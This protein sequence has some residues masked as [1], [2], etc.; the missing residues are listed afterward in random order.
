MGGGC[1]RDTRGSRNATEDRVCCASE[2]SNG[3]PVKGRVPSRGCLFLSFYG[4]NNPVICMLMNHPEEAEV[5]MILEMRGELLS[6]VCEQA[7]GGEIWYPSSR[8]T[9]AISRTVRPE[10]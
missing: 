10:K 8:L 2:Q 1:S 6:C 5:L 9:F 3:Q 4:R 7:R